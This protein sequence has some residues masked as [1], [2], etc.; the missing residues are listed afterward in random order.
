MS[1][2]TEL[3]ERAAIQTIAAVLGDSMQR[4]AFAEEAQQVAIFGTAS[5]VA[6]LP[7]TA[8]VSRERLIAVISLLTNGRSEEFRKKV[9]QFVGTA[10]T[11]SQRLPEVMAAQEAAAAKQN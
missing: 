4:I 10:V 1:E 9:A 7:E 8:Q 11:V 3:E 2:Q 5:I 6:S